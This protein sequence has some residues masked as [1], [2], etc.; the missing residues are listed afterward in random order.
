MLRSAQHDIGKQRASR[1]HT[2][3]SE[4]SHTTSTVVY[5]EELHFN[6][7]NTMEQI[8]EDS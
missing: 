8:D 6:R 2:E 3:R 4:V 7:Q 5:L 1:G